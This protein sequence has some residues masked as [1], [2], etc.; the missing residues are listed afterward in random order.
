MRRRQLLLSTLALAACG[1]KERPALPATPR[2]TSAAELIPPDLDVV[3]RLDLGRMKATLGAMTLELV[4]R[5]LLTR[6][7]G[8]ERTEPDALLLASLLEADVVY[9]GYRPSPLL[10]PLD[11]VL[12][13][14]GRF[15]PLTKTPAG[16]SGLVDLGA[17]V[18]YWDRQ[19]G[20]TSDRASPARLYVLG[21]RVR[22]FV[23]EAEIDAV[24]RSLDGLAGPRRLEP[25]EEG[26]LSLAARPRLLGKLAGGT[27]RELL[28]DSRSLELVADLQS[29]QARLR[30]S[31]LTASPEHASRLAG[32]AE[33]VLARSWGGWGKRVQVR[34]VAERLSLSLELRRAELVP[35]LTCL[36]G[37][38]GSAPAC[39]W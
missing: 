34:P 17:D 12:S 2:V 33:D 4:S 6:G 38:S 10:L 32:A 35:L 15:A 30:L 19:P 14:Q 22:A 9:L 18:R 24:E 31:L 13:L 11:R 20:K 16:F 39:P 8:D 23:S 21:D 5:D 25:P 28:E 29:D 37:A 7:A 1:P 27:L 3:V 26:T 36:R